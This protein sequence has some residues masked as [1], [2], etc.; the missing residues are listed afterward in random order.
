M[1]ISFREFHL[2]VVCKCNG[3]L[4]FAILDLLIL[5]LR[6]REVGPKSHLYVRVRIPSRRGEATTSIVVLRAAMIAIRIGLGDLM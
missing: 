1:V 3:P 2:F 4:P 6:C 5:V